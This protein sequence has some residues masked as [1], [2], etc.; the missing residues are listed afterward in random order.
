MKSFQEKRSP[1]A[2]RRASFAIP[3]GIAPSSIPAG[4]MY[5]QKYGD[6]SPSLSTRREGSSM[7]KTTRMKYLR[8]V[9]RVIL[10]VESF[11]DGILYNRSCIQPKGQRKPHMRRP[12]TVPKSMMR[13]LT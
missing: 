6:E 8:Y 9:R 1:K 12:K 13:P 7:T 4:H 5:L 2:S 11:F 3:R 10:F